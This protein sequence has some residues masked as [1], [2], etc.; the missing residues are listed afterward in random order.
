MNTLATDKRAQILHHLV[1]G[2]SMRATC[3]LTDVAKK[4]VERLLV[5]AGTACIKYQDEAMRNLNC[6]RLQMDEIWSFTYCK[7]ANVPR[8]NMFGKIGDTWTWVAIDADTKLIPDFHVGQRTTAVAIHFFESLAPRMA[9][10]VQLTTDGLHAYVVAVEEGFGCNV[11]FAQ[12]HK[13]YGSANKGGQT[14][15]SPPPCIGIKKKIISGNPDP[16]HISTSYVE[17]Q[18]LTLRMNNRRMT[19]LTNAFSKKLENH[20][21]MMGIHFMYYNFCRIHQTLR[22]TPAMEAGITDHVW[23]LEEVVNLLPW[24]HE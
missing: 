12:L 23:D 20:I 21:F 5:S 18:N 9:G 2:C 1:E 3:R 19:R 15:Y 8:E 16:A 13:I 17:R 22:V 10:K 11:D 24:Q 14:R 6:K 7:Q 4:T